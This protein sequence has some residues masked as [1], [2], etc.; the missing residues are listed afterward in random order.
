[1]SRLLGRRRIDVSA[2]R[3]ARAAAPL[4]PYEAFMPEDRSERAATIIGEGWQLA[5]HARVDLR[6]P[7]AWDEVCASNRS[8]HYHLHCW[9]GL[10]PLLAS[11]SE[12]RDETHLRFARDVAL[13]WAA[14]YP[15]LTTES[16]FA[17]YDMAIGLRAYRLG[18][19][20]DAGARLELFSD[21]D[22][23]TLTE[24]V[25]LHQGA[26]ADERRFSAHSN[27]GFYQALG[28]LAL[29]ARLPELPGMDEART[30]SESRLR[31]LIRQQFTE[32]GVH[33][34]HSPGYHLLVLETFDR[35]L[36]SRLIEDSWFSERRRP[37]PEALA[38]FVLPN[39]RFSMFGDTGHAFSPQLSHADDPELRFVMTAGR[40]GS[41]PGETT[42]TFADA[43]YVVIRDRWPKGH[44]DF[45]NCAYLAQI[46]GFHS[47]AHKH[48]DDL[49]FV[50]YDRGREIITDSGRYGFLGK[51]EPGSELWELGFN[52]SDPKRVYVESTR[53]HNT[54][55]IDG[56]SY[57]R[58]DVKPYGSALRQ[59][60]EQEGI[61]Y[62]E[63]EVKHFGTVRHSRM[64]LFKPGMW[65]VVLDHLSDSSGTQHCFSQRFHFAPELDAIRCEDSAR[66]DIPDE[67]ESLYMVPLLAGRLA[68]P[69]RGQEEPSL[70]GWVSRVGGSMTPAWTAAYVADGVAAHTFATLLCFA[71]DEPKVMADETRVDGSAQH[72]VLSWSTAGEQRQVGFSRVRG[73]SFRI[74]ERLLPRT[75]TPEPPATDV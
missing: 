54:V 64:L 62:S 40:E 75:T 6:P 20:I 58:R 38:W 51:T 15:S 31:K 67:A 41:P 60:G 27:H 44:H 63:C 18:Y 59:S 3:R 2:L 49:S 55:E 30:Q 57:P 39:G 25:V 19:L 36:A 11:Y 56:T 68:E 72:A 73:K 8:W 23:A 46:A 14:N 47:R 66:I 50:W 5:Q 21:D 13:D 45:S 28:Q 1:M 61:H 12:S 70:L 52:Y 53:A 4:R 33:R 74:T 32:D 29:A 69:V 26:L 10:G 24:S 9:N 71:R 16:P 37:I 43:G 17:W 7:L 35:M 22:V 65:L 48:A 42:R 34:E